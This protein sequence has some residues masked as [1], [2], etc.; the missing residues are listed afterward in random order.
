MTTTARA[1]DRPDRRP[2]RVTYRPER[3]HPTS[4]RLPVQDAQLIYAAALKLGISMSEYMR[5]A[6]RRYGAAVL[7]DGAP[8]EQPA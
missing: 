7:T 5:R 3:R 2:R 8:A 6:C 4:L 1:T